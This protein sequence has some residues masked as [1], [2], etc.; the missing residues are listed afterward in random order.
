MYGGPAGRSRSDRAIGRQD[1]RPLQDG[2]HFSMAITDT[3]LA[4]TRRAA[5]ITAEAVLDGIYVLR[6]PVPAN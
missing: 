5:Q 2:Q 4:L 1:D 6:T 3:N